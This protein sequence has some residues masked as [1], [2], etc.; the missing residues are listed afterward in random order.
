MDYTLNNYLVAQNS[1]EIFKRDIYFNINDLILDD[2]KANLDATKT[3]KE[4]YVKGIKVFIDYCNKY[5]I[6]EITPYPTINN[7]IK[8]LFINHTPIR[9][10]QH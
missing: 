6:S 5:D 9:T 7:K 8:I 10:G 3:T 2:F 4:T 1:K